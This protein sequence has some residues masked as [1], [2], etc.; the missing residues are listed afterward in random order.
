LFAEQAR[1]AF[2][3]GDLAELYEVETRILKQAVRR[4]SERFPDDFMFELSQEEF[5]NWYLFS[6]FKESRG[7]ALLDPLE[8]HFVL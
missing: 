5:K 1:R 3:W 2:N 7:Q 4:N 6:A 8:H